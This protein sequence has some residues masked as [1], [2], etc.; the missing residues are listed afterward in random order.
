MDLVK[1]FDLV[2]K[3]M[4]ELMI[5]KEKE[6]NWCAQFDEDRVPICGKTKQGNFVKI[7][8]H[9]NSKHM[10]PINMWNSEEEKIIE[11]R[12][13]GCASLN[14]AKGQRYSGEFRRVTGE[15]INQFWD[16]GDLDE[17]AAC[18]KDMKEYLKDLETFEIDKEITQ[19]CIDN[20]R[21][22][23]EEIMKVFMDGV[24]TE[25]NNSA[26]ME[27]LLTPSARE[28]LKSA[29]KQQKELGGQGAPK[30]L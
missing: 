4:Q 12:E 8:F 24:W 15:R 22:Y 26:A 11:I 23:E 27:D 21:K 20:I 14:T 17:F 9:T 7:G 29:L 30:S 19:Q 10:L 3:Q 5:K 28:K 2:I 13:W 16:E 6:G 1:E 25:E 18:I